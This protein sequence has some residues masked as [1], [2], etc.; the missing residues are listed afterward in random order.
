MIEQRKNIRKSLFYN[1][2]VYE[3]KTN[4]LLGVL[5]DLSVSGAQMM[6]EIPLSPHRVVELEFENTLDINPE[7]R[8]RVSAECCWCHDDMEFEGYDSGIR[9]ITLSR[10]ANEM[11]SNYS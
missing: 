9:F 6:S 8:A 2:K 5:T 1:I 4:R 7:R 10:Q 11:V 3:P